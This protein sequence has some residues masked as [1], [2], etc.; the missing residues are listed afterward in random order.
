MRTLLSP[1]DIWSMQIVVSAYCRVS[2][3]KDDQTNSLD[4]QKKYF[5]DY[6]LGHANWKLGEIYYDEGI[7]GTSVKKRKA[8]NRMVQDGLSGK[9]QLL[10]TKEVSRFARNTIDT[11]QYTRTLKERNV[12]VYFMTDNIYTLDS[13]GELRLT[14]MASLAQEES[15]KTSERV[16]WGQKR[17]MEQGVVFGGARLFGYSHEEGKISINPNEARIVRIIFEKFLNGTGIY[18]IA[19]ELDSEGLKPRSGKKWQQPTI[20][21]ILKNEKYC[22][23]LV[24]RK[25]LTIDFLTKKSIKNPNIDD[26][27]IQRDSHAAIVSREIWN[28]AQEELIRRTTPLAKKGKHTNRYWCSSKL[29]CNECGRGYTSKHKKVGKNNIHHYFRC[30]ASQIEGSKKTDIAGNSRGCDNFSI[31]EHT[32]RFLCDETMKFID[33]NKG[34]LLKEIMSE[35]GNIQHEQTSIRT[36]GLISK[37]DAIKNKKARAIN[38]ALEGII[39]GEDLKNQNERYDE[40]IKNI[41][42]QIAEIENRNKQIANKEESLKKILDE[43]EK[44][45]LFDEDR[46]LAYKDLIDKIIVCKNKTIII[47]LS[48]FDFGIKLKYNTTRTSSTYRLWLEDIF[49]HEETE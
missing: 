37:I 17:R 10:I 27:I 32:L 21:N 12:G 36:D 48:G 45:L 22:G 35:I 14:I 28:K 1:N 42:L 7:T 25:S 19:K 26:L 43:I 23:D 13:D 41:N 39:S 44:I 33:F 29:V 8:F 5:T 20:Y 4:S 3:D 2:T 15:R 31:R 49:L 16:K 40:E 11:L 47:Y 18:T 46:T 9:Y 6:I 24:Q 38:F 30:A 34:E